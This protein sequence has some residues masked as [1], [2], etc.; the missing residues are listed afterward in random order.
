VARAP[1][2][3]KI[4]I[5]RGSFHHEGA[6][7]AEPQPNLGISPAKPRRRK[8]FEE[9]NFFSELGVFAPLERQDKPG[10]SNILK[11]GYLVNCP[12]DK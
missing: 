12:F 4:A 5:E 7:A 8:G 9:K 2:G 3:G 1:G 11:G 6:S 10:R